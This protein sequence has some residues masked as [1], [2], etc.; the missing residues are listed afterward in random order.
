MIVPNW[1]QP[2]MSSTGE[3]TVLIY[4]QKNTTN[5]RECTTSIWD[6]DKSPNNYAAWKQ[7]EKNRVLLHIVW[8][9]SYKILKNVN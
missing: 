8:F 5:R 7:R 4:I 9:H 6:I 3:W 1:E 2:Q